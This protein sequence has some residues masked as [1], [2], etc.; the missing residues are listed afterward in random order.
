[1]RSER[2]RPW[3]GVCGRGFCTPHQFLSPFHLG[4]GLGSPLVGGS[5]IWKKSTRTGPLLGCGGPLGRQEDGGSIGLCDFWFS[6]LGKERL[7]FEYAQ[8]C[9]GASLLFLILQSFQPGVSPQPGKR[10]W[11]PRV[12]QGTPA[13]TALPSRLHLTVETGLAGL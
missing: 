1:M 2:G 10:R 13:S 4:R 3:G 9:A 7:T 5:R 6:V 12:S 11:A 8:V